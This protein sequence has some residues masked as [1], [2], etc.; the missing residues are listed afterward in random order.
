MKSTT[1]SNIKL[2]VKSD[3]EGVRMYIQMVD[4]VTASL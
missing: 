2:P 4:V 1:Y 3:Y